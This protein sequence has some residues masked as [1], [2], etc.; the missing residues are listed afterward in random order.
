[1]VLGGFGDV[2]GPFDFVLE[3]SVTENRAAVIDQE[4]IALAW[5]R[6][7]AASCHL[8]EQTDLFSRPSKNDAADRRQVKTFCKDHAVADDLGL[9]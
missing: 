7:Q 1:M 3:Q 6:S 9:A 4:Q 2:Q 5:R 8:P